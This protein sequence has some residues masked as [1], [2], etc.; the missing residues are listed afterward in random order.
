[1]KI[2]NVDVEDIALFT[3]E[4]WWYAQAPMV[5]LDVWII[6]ERHWGIDAIRILAQKDGRIRGVRTLSPREDAAE[7]S[8]TKDEILRSGSLYRH[9]EE[10]VRERLM[11]VA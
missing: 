8:F 9:I 3:N 2:I 5:Q 1:M 10:Q 7:F 4:G 11:E 6:H